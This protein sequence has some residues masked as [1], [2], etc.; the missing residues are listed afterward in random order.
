MHGLVHPS[1]HDDDVQAGVARALERADR[2]RPEDAFV[3][4][5][6]AVEIGRDD[7]DV[8][9][10]SGRKLDQPPCVES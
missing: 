10:E 6:R 4:D 7:R 9:R 5:E 2:P 1:G 8:A 3:P